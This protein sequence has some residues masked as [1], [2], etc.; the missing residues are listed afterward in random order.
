MS[1]GA[2][3][4]NLRLALRHTSRADVVKLLPDPHDPDVLARVSVGAAT[5]SDPADEALFAGIPLRHTCR[6]P[7][8]TRP[9]PQALLDDLRSAAESEDVELCILEDEESRR[10]AAEFVAEGDVDQMGD[11]AFR[12]E[13]AAWTRPNRTRLRAALAELLARSRAGSAPASGGSLRPGSASGSDARSGSPLAFEFSS[14]SFSRS[15]RL[16][17]QLMLRMGYGLA[18][19]PTPRRPVRDVLR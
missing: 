7:F 1:C 15:P 10:R 12:A 5:P 17:P 14:S 8:A 11:P 4:L 13:L 18:P 6:H 19:R 16:H 3:L 9:L 2:A